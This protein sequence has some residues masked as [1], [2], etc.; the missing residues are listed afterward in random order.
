M[1]ANEAVARPGSRVP[2]LLQ[3][4]GSPVAAVID[5]DQ[6]RAGI[7]F[8]LDCRYEDIKKARETRAFCVFAEPAN[9]FRSNMLRNAQIVRSLLLLL[10]S[11]ALRSGL[12]PLRSSLLL[13]CCSLL[14]LWSSLL[15]LCCSLLLL[16]SSFLLLSCSL[17]L[18][19]CSLLLCCGLTLRCSLTLRCNL[20]LGCGFLLCSHNKP[21][22]Y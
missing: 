12:L 6:H 15:L 16:W 13:L 22:Y 7:F 20:L 2:A 11:L 8:A 4:S 10:R 9:G 21:P 17:L 14:L 3:Q 1:S 19:G 5:R 18:L